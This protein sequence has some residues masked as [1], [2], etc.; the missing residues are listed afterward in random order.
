MIALWVF[1]YFVGA[2]VLYY[3]IIREYGPSDDWTEVKDRGIITIVWP[4]TLVVI[5]IIWFHDNVSPRIP[6]P[7]KWL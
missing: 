4:L 5:A 3:I 1:L 2:G 6:K 7:P